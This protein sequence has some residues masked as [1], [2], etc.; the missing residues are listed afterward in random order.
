MRELQDEAIVVTGCGGFI[1][2]TLS[3]ALLAAGRCVIGIDLPLGADDRLR[4][5]RLAS[6]AAFPSFSLL[7]ADICAPE[8]PGRLADAG[9][10]ISA[11]VHLA[12]FTGVRQSALEP[13]RCLNTNVLGTLNVLEACRQLGIPKLVFA[14]SSSIYGE[15]AA[16]P[17]NEEECTEHQ[18]SAYAASKKAGEDLCHVYN[19]MYGISATIFRFFTVYGPAGRPDMLPFRLVQRTI[20]GRP[21]YI[22]GDGRQRRDFTYVD[23]VVRGVQGGLVLPGFEI[24]NLGAHHPIEVGQAVRMVEKLTGVRANVVHKEPNPADP[25]CTWADVS[26]AQRVLGWSARTDFEQGMANL[27]EWYMANRAWASELT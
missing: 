20:E 23:D 10:H 18:L 4:R 17:W 6:L 13:Q 15:C 8:L 12:A 9:M 2:S 14:S 19:H 16:L 11:V 5:W 26:K 3:A 21:I 24:I 7:H 27:V 1:G 25:P 22:Y